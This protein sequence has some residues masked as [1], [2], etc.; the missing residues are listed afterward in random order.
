MKVE[1]IIFLYNSFEA[2][3]ASM[4]SELRDYDTSSVADK[5]A[6]KDHKK[7]QVSMVYVQAKTE[8]S[9]PGQGGILGVGG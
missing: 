7:R 4:G 3:L 9:L 6:K 5:V 2:W 8:G 1:I